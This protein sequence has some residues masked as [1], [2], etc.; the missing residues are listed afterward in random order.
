[1]APY[2]THQPGTLINYRQRDWM[3]LPSDDVE[4]LRIKPLGGSDEETFAGAGL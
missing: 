2:T 4:I 3:V 1:M